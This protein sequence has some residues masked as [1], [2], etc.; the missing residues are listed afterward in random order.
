MYTWKPLSFLGRTSYFIVFTNEKKLFYAYAKNLD[1]F[2]HMRKRVYALFETIRELYPNEPYNFWHEYFELNGK[3]NYFDGNFF[4]E[5][6]HLL[7]IPIIRFLYDHQRKQF[8]PM[9]RK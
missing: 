6:H 2:D 4:R 7:E 3:R 5:S 9:E 1:E 8:Y